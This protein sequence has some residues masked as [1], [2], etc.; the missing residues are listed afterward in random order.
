MWV[1]VD[2]GFL[3]SFWPLYEYTYTGEVVEDEVVDD[4]GG[5]VEGKYLQIFK[6]KISIN[7]SDNTHLLMT[8]CTVMIMFDSKKHFVPW[9]SLNI[10]EFHYFCMKLLK[11]QNCVLSWLIK[12]IAHPESKNPI[13][14]FPDELIFSFLIS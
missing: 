4:V 11:L 13:S 3:A 10:A 9:L 7:P 5:D 8:F 14:E 6:S 2:V 12:V 1:D